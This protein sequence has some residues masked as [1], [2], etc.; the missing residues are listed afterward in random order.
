MWNRQSVY[1]S[2]K[3]VS[4]RIV[5]NGKIVSQNV[6]CLRSCVSIV[7]EEGKKSDRIKY[8][9][10]LDAVKDMDDSIRKVL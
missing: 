1:E 8:Q 2:S 9:E 6:E 3:C 5:W 7:L 4:A 10:M